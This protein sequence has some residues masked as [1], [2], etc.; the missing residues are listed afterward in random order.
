MPLR[1]ALTAAHRF[2][3]L[4]FGAEIDASAYVRVNSIQARMHDG[5]E[6]HAGEM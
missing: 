1:M 5:Y 2:G 4:A 3:C 6:M